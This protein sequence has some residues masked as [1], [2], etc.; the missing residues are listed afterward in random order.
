M[1]H[2]KLVDIM[3]YDCSKGIFG[4]LVFTDV[5][6]ALVTLCCIVVWNLIFAIKTWKT[7]ET[8]DCDKY[9]LTMKIKG[10]QYLTHDVGFLLMEKLKVSSYTINIKFLLWFCLSYQEN[11]QLASMSKNIQWKKISTAA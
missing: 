4:F 9:L 2:D 8:T 11:V 5:A 7:D 1:L 3:T 6:V 10:K